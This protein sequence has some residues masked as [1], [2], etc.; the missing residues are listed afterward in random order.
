AGIQM[1]KNSREADKAAILSRFSGIFNHLDLHGSLVEEFEIQFID[2]SSEDAQLFEACGV[3]QCNLEQFFNLVDEYDD[4][5]KAALFYLTDI[6]GY[7]MED[8]ISKLDDVCLFEGYLKEAA[9]ELFD[10]CY[11]H[12]IPENLRCYINYE[13][14]AHDCE[15]GGDMYE[16]EFGGKTYTCTNAA[17][18]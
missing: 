6:N 14:F 5:E 1:I 9:E 15:L 12:E 17:C 4:R 10:E 16:F 8:A 13:A 11:A 7:S 18:V 2:G 3:N